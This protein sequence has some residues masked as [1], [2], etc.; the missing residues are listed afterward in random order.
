M[1][2]MTYKNGDFGIIIKNDGTKIRYGEGKA[3]FPESIDLKITDY[4]TVGCR[5][6]HESS[7]KNG[8]HG[9]K[10]F[11]F[12]LLKQMQPGTEVAIGGGN[13]LDH[14]DLYEILIYAKARKLF[15][16]L[17]INSQSIDVYRLMTYLERKLIHGLGLSIHLNDVYLDNNSFYRIYSKYPDNIVFHYI[18]GIH[19]FSDIYEVFN[20]FKNPKVLILG[21]K[22]HGFGKKKQSKVDYNIEDL[23]ENIQELKGKHV[24]FDNLAC[25][26]LNIEENFP[27]EYKH[28]YMGEDGKFTMY[29]DAVSQT[30]AKSSI[31]YRHQFQ[32]MTLKEAFKLVG[33]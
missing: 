8:K 7:T 29:V 5:F 9:D 26:Q 16:N 20:N 32:N 2:V 25:S 18:A 15:A 3:E 19:R 11:I 28:S 10:N 1:S 30:F 12:D 13:P 4:C 22:F 24:S 6:C 23:C 31:E 14:P 27:K 21:Y 33:E 17:T